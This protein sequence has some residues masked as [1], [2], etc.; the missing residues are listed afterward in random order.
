LQTGTEESNQSIAAIADQELGSAGMGWVAVC[1]LESWERGE[2]NERCKP[3]RRFIDPLFGSRSRGI[4]RIHIESVQA[5]DGLVARNQR[6]K[7]S[8]GFF[9]F[10]QFLF[11][12]QN[13]RRPYLKIMAS[14]KIWGP[15]PAQSTLL[16]ARAWSLIKLG[17]PIW[18]LLR[19]LWAQH[20]PLW[21][22]CS[23]IF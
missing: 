16:V 22:L 23:R 11:L 8:V 14:P 6:P 12:V 13:L 5:G 20:V 2:K 1:R 19:R 10:S 9:F 7:V 17:N 4:R 15:V 18:G 21:S 3:W